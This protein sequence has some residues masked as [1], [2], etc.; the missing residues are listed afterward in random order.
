MSMAT[1]GAILTLIVFVA[2]LAIWLEDGQVIPL[3][4]M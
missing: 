3:M 2:V 1:I 4:A